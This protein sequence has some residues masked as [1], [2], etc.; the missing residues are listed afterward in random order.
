MRS[1]LRLLLRE[2]GL[3]GGAVAELNSDR[4]FWHHLGRR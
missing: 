2:L 1:L 4:V 3:L